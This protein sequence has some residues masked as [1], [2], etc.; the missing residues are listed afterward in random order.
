[1]ASEF[2]F[3][4]GRRAFMVPKVYVIEGNVRPNCAAKMASGS[5]TRKHG[6]SK[7]PFT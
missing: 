7:Y 6:W 5:A 3:C 1:M 4:V 2:F